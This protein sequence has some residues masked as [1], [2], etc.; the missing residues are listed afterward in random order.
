LL[1]G[2]STECGVSGKDGKKA[3]GKKVILKKLHGMY[4]LATKDFFGK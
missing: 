1:K 3:F 4:V 2:I